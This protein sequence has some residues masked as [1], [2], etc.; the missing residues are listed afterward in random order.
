MI[1]Q[2]IV[3]VIK[4][5]F[6]KNNIAKIQ[7]HP[8]IFKGKE[9]EYLND[10][11]ESTFVSSVGSFVDRFEDDLKTYTGS[12]YV[13]AVVNGTSALHVALKLADVNVNDEVIIPS[14]SFVATANAVK[15]CGAIPH[16]VDNEYDTLGMDPDALKSWLKNIAEI[17]NGICRNRLTGSCI[18]AIVPMHTFGHPCRMDELNEIAYNYKLNLVEDSAES[19]EFLSRD[20][21]RYNWQIGNSKF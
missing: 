4:S 10:C 13:I 12:K 3:K 21:Y 14:I 11:I 16:F 18:K 15:Y 7:L 17:S 2:K 20:S 19:W 5:E 1:A 6:L 9:L 8:P